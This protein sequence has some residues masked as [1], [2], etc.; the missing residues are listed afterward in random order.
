MKITDHENLDPKNSDSLAE[1]ARQ[2]Q[3]LLQDDGTENTDAD[4]ILAESGETAAT[5]EP[6]GDTVNTEEA[7][8]VTAEK[9]EGRGQSVRK[10]FQTK[11]VRYGSYSAALTVL[12]IVA[13]VVV[14]LIASALPGNLKSADLSANSLYSVGK[15]TEK[16]LD[17]LKEPITITVFSSRENAEDALVKLLEHYGDNKNITVEYK[18]P[19]L[20]PSAASAYSDLTAGS[21]VVKSEKKEQ[22][23]DAGEIFVSDYSSYYS[24]GNMSTTFDGEGQIT[25]A[26]QYVTSGQLPKMYVIT[27]HGESELSSTVSSLVSKQNIEVGTLNLMTDGSIPEDCS[28]LLIYAPVSDY[29]ADEARMI[30]DYLDQGGSVMAIEYYTEEKLVNY[31]SILNAY[32]LQTEDGVVMETANH[33]YQYPMYALPEI[34]SSEITESLASAN[35]NILMPNAL[36]MVATEAEGTEVTP[37]LQTTSGAYLKK[38]NGGQLDSVEKEDGDV[39]GQFLLAALAEKSSEG[40]GKLIAISSSSLIDD[41]VTQSFTLGNLDL[42]TGCLSYLTADDGVEKVS[43]DAKSMTPDTITVPNLQSLLWGA[44]VVVLVPAAVIVAGLIIWLRRRKK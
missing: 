9:V 35:V 37:L 32:G 28:C 17:T 19:A 39:V 7:P 30:I 34:A 41:G 29:T 40:A 33:Y 3:D 15:Q 25:S 24:T 22:K 12:V 11:S 1:K 42:F 8:A 13:A 4:G 21:V 5:G 6:E 10:S 43:I 23:I 2:L 44:V 16:V 27:G 36:G 18:D 31:E 20:N 14:N 26:I 38:V